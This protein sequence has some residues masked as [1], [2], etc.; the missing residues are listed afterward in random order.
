LIIY[1]AGAAVGAGFAVLV[2]IIAGNS[3]TPILIGD[4]AVAVPVALYLLGIWFVR[5][6][7][8]LKAAEQMI[9]PVFALIILLTPPLL[10]LEGIALFTLL[11]VIVRTHFVCK[12][13][14]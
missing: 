4:Y 12:T 13:A 10:A 2:D 3:N 6:R 8:V 9:L 14:N 1:L 7:F 11:S 5:D